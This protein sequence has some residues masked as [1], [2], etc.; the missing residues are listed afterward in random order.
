M[1]RREEVH[2]EH[3]ARAPAPFGDLADRDRRGV[4][5]KH[6]LLADGR[7]DLGQDL[8]LELEVLE[9]R[10]D[11]EVA[12]PEAAV[13]Q[14]RR[15]PIEAL[16]HLEPAETPTLAPLLERVAHVPEPSTEGLVRGVLHPN[17]DAYVGGGAGDSGPHEPGSQDAELR[18]VPGRR[19]PF[20]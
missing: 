3:T 13:V 6:A 5:G 14:R 20:G 10:L 12:P 16:S 18:H 9:H 8:T 1:H 19:V 11:D 4:A 15:N 17:R 2:P 7:L